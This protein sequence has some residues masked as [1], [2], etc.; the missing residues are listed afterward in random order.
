MPRGTEREPGETREQVDEL[1]RESSELAFNDSERSFELA[2]RSEALARRLEYGEGLAYSQCYQAYFYFQAGRHE[3]ALS[4]AANAF[5]FFDRT[6]DSN[7][8]ARVSSCLSRLYWSLGDYE[9]AIRHGYRSLE[10]YQTLENLP[11]RAWTLNL[12]GGVVHDTGDHEQALS[13]HERSLRLFRELGDEEGEGRA[14]NGMGAV[15]SAQGKHDLAREQHQRSLEISRSI[16]NKLSEARALTDLGAVFQATGDPNGALDC[17]LVALRLRQELKNRQAQTTS[18]IHLGRLYNQLRDHG[19]ARGYL[20]QAL[21]IAVEMNVPPKIFQAHEALSHSFALTGEDRKALEHY[22]EFHRI[23]EQVTGE[24]SST[25]LKNLEIRQGV[26]RA[27]REAE[28]ERLRHIEL[29][30]ALERLKATQAQLIHSAKMASLGDLVAGLVHEI[31]T[32]IGVI[33]ASADVSQRSLE[34]LGTT[35]PDVDPELRRTL[36]ILSLNQRAIRTSSERIARLMRSLQSF[37][38]LDRAE[39]QMAN[40]EHGIEATLDLLGPKLEKRVEVVRD[41]G[42]LPRIACYPSQLHQAFMTILVN[43]VESIEGRGAVAVETGVDGSE[44][45]VKISDTGRGIPPDR[46]DRIFDVGFSEKESRVRMHVGLSNVQTIVRRHGGSVS[47]LSEP[48]NGTV[49]TIRLPRELSPAQLAA[50]EFSTFGVRQQPRGLNAVDT[51]S[52]PRDE[53]PGA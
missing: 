10:L 35:L 51:P 47:V 39:L 21:A 40:L 1:N 23:K 16:G 45:F 7:G 30:Q 46:L 18:L 22:L 52:D 48:G 29:A 2:L 53:T 33:H 9:K 37:A 34:K 38:Q 11:E 49:F 41:F 5:D 28:I 15:Y 12:L 31:N 20:Q 32:P 36:D 8:Q 27:E 43:A 14:L 25:R 50:S 6:K 19:T 42:N 4:V 17:H 24:E 13:L 3:E 26:E 44:I